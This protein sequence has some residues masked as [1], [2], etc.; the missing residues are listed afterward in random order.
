MLDYSD[1]V[2]SHIIARYQSDR[3]YS[4]FGEVLEFTDVN[5]DG[6]DELIIASPRRS[7]DWTEE[8]HGGK[9]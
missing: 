3:A 4:R 7:E 5:L 9:F 1:D 2:E 8:S 6:R